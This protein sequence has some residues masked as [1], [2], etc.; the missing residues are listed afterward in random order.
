VGIGISQTS[1]AEADA[2]ALIKFGQNV[3]LRVKSIFQRQV[4]EEGKDFSDKTT[5]SSELVSDVSMKGISISERYIDSVAH[6]FY[7]LVQYRKTEYDSLVTSEIQ[8]EILAM[9]ARNKLEEEKREEELRAEKT[10]N[11]QEEK[12]K[13]EELRAQKEQLELA[14]QQLQ[15]EE[16]H[17][18]LYL[19]MH[20]EFL[21]ASPPEKAISLRNGEISDA[22]NSLMIR[23]GISPLQFGGGL[24]ALRIWM[25]EFSGLAVFHHKKFDQQEGAVKIQVLHRAGELTKSSLSFGVVQAVGLIADSGYSFKRSK[26]SLFVSANYTDPD[27]AYT[28]ISFYGDKRKVSLGGTSFPFYSHFKNHLGFVLEATAYFDKDFR[29]QYGDPLVFGGGIRFQTDKTFS[30]QLVFEENEQLSLIFEFQF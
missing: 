3:Q 15:Q 20:A 30:T 27:L 24:Y 22:G 5:I 12:R 23:G 18:R 25:F 26:Y 28:T 21:N 19:K 8:R 1:S 13:K 6:T 10:K 7:S 29:N 4:K 16:Q 2:N 9:K 17:K 11:A 14:Q